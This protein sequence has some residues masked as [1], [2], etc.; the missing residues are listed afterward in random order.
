MSGA[1]IVYL[2][3]VTLLSGA[4]IS[5]LSSADKSWI[6]WHFSRLGE[7]GRLS[8]IIFNIALMLAGAMLIILGIKIKYAI[9]KLIKKIKLEHNFKTALLYRLLYIVGVCLISVGLFPFDRFP[10]IHNIAGY[11]SLVGVLLVCYFSP[12]LLPVFTK[13]YIKYSHFLVATT[14]IIYTLYFTIHSL[15]LLIV[16][17]IL[18]VFVYI[19]LLSFIKEIYNKIK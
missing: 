19:W 3:G 15:R 16:E 17:F 13:R 11:G 9:N 18:F 10:L 5:G 6:Q 1:Q 4:L 7:G 8:A 12:L 2:F 14:V